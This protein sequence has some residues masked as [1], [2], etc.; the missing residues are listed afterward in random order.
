MVYGT[1]ERFH[2]FLF[3]LRNGNPTAVRQFSEELG[4]GRAQGTSGCGKLILGE[5]TAWHV[6]ICF[7]LQH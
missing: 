1:R 4:L 3:R 5:P 2:P 6:G 7:Q